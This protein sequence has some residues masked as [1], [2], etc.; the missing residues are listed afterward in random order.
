MTRAYPGEEWD[1][2]LAQE[3]VADERKAQDLVAQAR[4]ILQDAMT[5][6]SG[7]ARD[8]IEIALADLPDREAWD[9]EINEARAA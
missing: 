1:G 4:S 5:Y 2:V 7:T 9:E 3:S 8:Q 6:T